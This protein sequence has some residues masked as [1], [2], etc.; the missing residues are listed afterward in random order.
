MAKKSY[1]DKLAKRWHEKQGEAKIKTATAIREFEQDCRSMG[2][3]SVT[4]GCLFR[5]LVG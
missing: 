5:K 2:R 3:A 4:I 1:S